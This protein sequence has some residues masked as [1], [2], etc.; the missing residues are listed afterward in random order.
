LLNATNHGSYF[1]RKKGDQMTNLEIAVL[2]GSFLA[3]SQVVIILSITEAWEIL[4]RK[5]KKITK[6][7]IVIRINRD[8]K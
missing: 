3:T 5:N 1:G 8:I 2:F 6:R 4:F 7:N